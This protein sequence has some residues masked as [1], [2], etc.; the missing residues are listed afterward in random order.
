MS[1]PLL[2]LAVLPGTWLAWLGVLTSCG[3][4]RWVTHWREKKRYDWVMLIFSLCSQ[5]NPH[6][7]QSIE[8][9]TNTKMM[10]VNQKFDKQYKRDRL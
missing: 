4:T 10:S 6:P 3:T 2:P 8:Q 7:W 5:G 1:L 9:G